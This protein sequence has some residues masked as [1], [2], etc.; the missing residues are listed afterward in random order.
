M[1]ISHKVRETSDS[2]FFIYKTIEMEMVPMKKQTNGFPSES[3]LKYYRT[4]YPPGTRIQLD[5]MDDPHA[6]PVG[7]KGTIT[8]IDDAGNA[9]MKWDNGRSLSLIIG[10]DKFHELQLE[11]NRK[12]IGRAVDGNRN[13]RSI[14]DVADFIIRHGQYGD[15][16][17]VTENHTPFMKTQGIYISQI[18]DTEYRDE[19]QKILTPMQ[20][21]IEMQ[22]S[23][24]D[25]EVQ[26]EKTDIDISQI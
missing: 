12:L 26:E 1:L 22:I 21:E 19:L 3:T 25:N 20:K 9:L 13:L 14:E 16:E 7:T 8:G 2:A 23:D 5:E 18:D 10:V 4:I 17:I 11:N 15:I 24:S 6:I